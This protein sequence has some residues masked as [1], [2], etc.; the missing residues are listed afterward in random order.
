ME[1]PCG[2]QR[3]GAQQQPGERA[4]GCQPANTQPLRACKGR[5][6]A[7]AHCKGRRLAELKAAAAASPENAMAISSRLC[8]SG[9]RSATNT[10]EAEG[11][12]C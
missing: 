10:C 5:Q 8:P 11:F 6:A 2:G 9:E 12:Q 3:E 4:A 7:W 1:G